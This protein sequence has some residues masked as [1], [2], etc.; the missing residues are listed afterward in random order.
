MEKQ[1]LLPAVRAFLNDG[2][3]GMFVGGQFSSSKR[4]K[5][6][7]TVD[8]GSGKQLA[9]VYAGDAGDID[10]AI[11]AAREAFRR[12]GWPE[13]KP[14]ER[15]VYLHRLA[16][17]VAQ[18]KAVLAEIESL[19][20]GKPLPQAQWDVENFSATMRYYADLALHV[21]YRDPIP[22]A[23]HEARTVRHAY[24]V[25]GAIFPWNFPFLLVGWGISA[26]LA[27]GNVVVIKPAEDTPLSTLYLGLLVREAGIPDGVINIVPGLGDTAGQ[28]LASH[29]GL[30][31]RP[32]LALPRWVEWLRRPAA[33]IW[34]P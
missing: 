11:T 17:L 21:S 31:R 8:P 5:T 32:S 20:V 27:A 7:A 13:M 26:A 25:C 6:F 22:A 14:N 19:D 1:E 2:P 18:H 23:G 16:D 30:N 29:P 34:F 28:A 12:S 15:G 3:L 9:E 33:A 24:G 10:D 4:K